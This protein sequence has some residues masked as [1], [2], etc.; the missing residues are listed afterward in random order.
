ML[1]QGD[2]AIMRDAI[3]P[4]SGAV[5]R[6][7]IDLLTSSIWRIPCCHDTTHGS[8]WQTTGQDASDALVPGILPLWEEEWD[9]P[10]NASSMA[11]ITCLASPTMAMLAT[12]MMGALSSGLMATRNLA[13]CKPK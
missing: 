13:S 10:A 12:F 11:G 6:V 9:Y 3:H 8:P 4:R 5:H 2:T 7:P 1:R